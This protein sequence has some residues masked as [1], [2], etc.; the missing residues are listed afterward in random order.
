[1]GPHLNIAA[2]ALSCQESRMMEMPRS[3]RNA[4]VGSLV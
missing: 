1:M 4:V 2:T 3:G